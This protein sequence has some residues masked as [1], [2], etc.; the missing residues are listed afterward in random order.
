MKPLPKAGLPHNPLLPGE[1]PA[2]DD[3]SWD[4]PETWDPTLAF[5]RHPLLYAGYN[6][7][8]INDDEWNGAGVNEPVWPTLFD[9]S[10]MFRPVTIDIRD[11]ATGFL[12]CPD[13]VVRPVFRCLDV[14]KR[15]N[16]M[17]VKR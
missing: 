16:R 2:W 6:F 4:N 5:Q 14:P 7:D 9:A 17:I 3:Y 12:E 11:Y 1:L 8:A 13:Y 10:V 15:P